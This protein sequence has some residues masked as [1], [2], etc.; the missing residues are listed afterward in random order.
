MS[1]HAG[2]ATM[3][4]RVS[5]LIPLRPPHCESRGDGRGAGM[6]TNANDDEGNDGTDDDDDDDGKHHHTNVD[7]IMQTLHSS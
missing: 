4:R 3:T 5:C 7:N 6:R 2:P 1:D